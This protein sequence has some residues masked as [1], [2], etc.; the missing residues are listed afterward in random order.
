MNPVLAVS[1]LRENPADIDPLSWS[2]VRRL[3]DKGLKNDPEMRRIYTL[4]TFTGLRTSE[5]IALKWVDI[6]WTSEPLTPVIK[7]SFTKRDG[8]RP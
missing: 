7:H 1:R 2:E 6:D 3:F 4:A 5:L 8:I